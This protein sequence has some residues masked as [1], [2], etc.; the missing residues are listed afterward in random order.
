MS[1]DEN[2]IGENIIGK[3]YSNLKWVDVWFENYRD[4]LWINVN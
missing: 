3:N 4:L 2:D 1:E